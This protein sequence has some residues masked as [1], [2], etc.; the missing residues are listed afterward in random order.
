[1][2][3]VQRNVVVCLEKTKVILLLY[4]YIKDQVYSF[5]LKDNIFV[6]YVLPYFGL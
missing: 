1:M 3:L 2:R 6:I 5:T 4:M